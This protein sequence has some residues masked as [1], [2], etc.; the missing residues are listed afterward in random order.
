M[1]LLILYPCISGCDEYKTNEGLSSYA[2]V[3][4]YC[5]LGTLQDYLRNNVLDLNNFSSMAL[6]IAAGLAH[7]H[8]EIRKGGMVILLYVYY[9]MNLC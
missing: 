7:L 2:I 6:S 4:S 3:V 8:T 5:P 1:K 9:I